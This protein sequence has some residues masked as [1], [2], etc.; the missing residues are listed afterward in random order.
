[1]TVKITL[2]H[3]GVRDMLRGAEG[4]IRQKAARIAAA[5]GPGFESEAFAGHRR[6]LGRVW[7]ATAEARAAE[8]RDMAL[9]RALDA[10]R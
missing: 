1:M 7:A 8:A 2:D 10:G 5:A 4:V 3:A 9:T 6:A